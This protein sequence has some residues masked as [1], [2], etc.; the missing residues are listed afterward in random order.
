L[1]KSTNYEAP[2]YAAFS[3]LPSLYPSLVQIFSST[4]CSQTPSDGCHTQLKPFPAV[5]CIS[6]SIVL[7]L[8][9]HNHLEVQKACTYSLIWFL[10][11]SL[12]LKRLLWGEIISVQL[13]AKKEKAVRMKGTFFRCTIKSWKLDFERIMSALVLCPL[14]NYEEWR[15]LG[16]YPVWL[17]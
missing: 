10:G 4:P 1:A 15:I 8:G 6:S 5:V 2:R 3:T 17:L 11:N 13:I 7:L 16:C 12:M 14:L 9:D